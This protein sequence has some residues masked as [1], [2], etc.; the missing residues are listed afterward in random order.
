MLAFEGGEREI[1]EDGYVF[2]QFYPFFFRPAPLSCALHVMLYDDVRRHVPPP[3]A[4]A[5]KVNKRNS[6]LEIWLI[7]CHDFYVGSY[8]ILY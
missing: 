3:A 8:I 7:F 5:V 6:S 1:R 4:R 2:V